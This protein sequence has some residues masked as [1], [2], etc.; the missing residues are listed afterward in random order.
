M[1]GGYDDPEEAVRDALKGNNELIDLSVGDI[2]GGSYQQFG[3]ESD[4]IASS[5]GK[6]K[7]IED[8]N[9]VNKADISRSL[10]TLLCVTIGQTMA[11]L[12]LSGGVDRVIV[13]GNPFECLEFLQMLQMGVDYFSQHKVKAYFSNYSTN[14]NL[15]GLCR[16]LELKGILTDLTD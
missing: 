11:L 10:L 4:L 7:Y 12:A 14:I 16:Q 1:T 8:I 6:L 9:S 2:Y 5:F 15:I 13:L 3:L